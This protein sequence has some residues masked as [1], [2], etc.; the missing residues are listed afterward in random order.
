MPDESEPAPLQINLT[1]LLIQIFTPQLSVVL[2]GM[3]ANL[4]YSAIPV[5]AGTLGRILTPWADQL[6][7]YDATGMPPAIIEFYSGL[8]AVVDHTIAV[9]KDRE[10]RI[11]TPQ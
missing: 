10:P 3:F 1:D 7:A 11:I 6:R 9:K 5:L 8:S 2:D 4:G